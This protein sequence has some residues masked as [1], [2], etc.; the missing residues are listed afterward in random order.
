MRKAWY[1]GSYSLWILFS[2]SILEP[3]PNTQMFLPCLTISHSYLYSCF[4]LLV[5]VNGV[6][7]SYRSRYL[8]YFSVV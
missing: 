5:M 3:L 4:C 8:L 2:R 7:F 1:F 6:G